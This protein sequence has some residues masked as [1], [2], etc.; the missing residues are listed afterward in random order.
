MKTA[1][2]R[3]REKA[4]KIPMMVPEFV[5]AT[6]I[7]RMHQNRQEVLLSGDYDRLVD[8]VERATDEECICVFS[9]SSLRAPLNSEAYRLYMFLAVKVF[10]SMGADVPAD[11]LRDGKGNLDTFHEH[12][13]ES[14][15]R[16]IRGSQQRSGK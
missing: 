13:L 12:I 2:D 5:S 15:R 1:T 7:A 3:M 11:I 16:K 9:E 10:T 6:L 8:Y 14:L 4:A